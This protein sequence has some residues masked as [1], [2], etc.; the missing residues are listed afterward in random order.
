MYMMGLPPPRTAALPHPQWWFDP[1]SYVTVAV[2]LF[3]A[4]PQGNTLSLTVH[5][6]STGGIGISL[7]AVGST[8]RLLVPDVPICGVS[9]AYACMHAAARVGVAALLRCVPPCWPFC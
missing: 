5:R 9:V 3:S 1:C 8:A 4:H 7:Q 2:V 6:G